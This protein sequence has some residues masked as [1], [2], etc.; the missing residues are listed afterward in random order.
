MESMELNIDQYTNKELEDILYLN[1]PYTKEEITI[2]QQKLKQTVNSNSKINNTHKQNLNHF[3]DKILNKLIVNDNLYN[4]PINSYKNVIK[5]GTD[6]VIV[7]QSTLD[8]NTRPDFTNGLTADLTGAPPGILNPINYRTIKRSVNIDSKFR[9]NYYSTISTD[10]Q[11]NLP[12]KFEN[13]I[14]MRLSSFEIPLT[15]YAISKKNGNNKMMVEWCST[16][17]AKNMDDYDKTS[18]ITLPDGNYE[19]MF[20]GS[21]NSFSIEI[22]INNALTTE[23]DDGE[24]PFANPFNLKFTVDRVS[25]RSIFSQSTSSETKPTSYKIT[26]NIGNDGKIESEAPLPLKMGWHLGY[27]VGSYNA[28]N[29]ES[30]VSEG[31]CYVAGPKYIYLAIDDYNNNVNNYFISAFNE[32]IGSK[33][34]IARINMATISQNNG[35]Y[36]LGQDD[37]FST[38]INRSRSYFGPVDISKLRITLY[39]DYSRILDLNNMDWSLSLMFECVYS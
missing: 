34:I 32:S 17:I 35:I 12:Y 18:I 14:N 26:F 24:A 19:Q 11:V 38:Q 5:S 20:I 36:Q 31:I 39:D 22:A 30:I 13:V 33:N 21:T 6:T 2:S 16:G 25:G 15:Y 37:G 7:K 8:G 4:S 28:P 9:P 1:Y 10:M 29:G 27:R 3:I 23:N